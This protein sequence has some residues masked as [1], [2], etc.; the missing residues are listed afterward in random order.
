[1]GLFLEGIYF[2]NCLLDGIYLG[3][4]LLDGIYLGIYLLDG[5]I[6]ML[7]QTYNY[8]ISEGKGIQASLESLRVPACTKDHLN[9]L[10]NSSHRNRLKQM[11]NQ[12][13]TQNRQAKQC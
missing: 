1:V 7:M 5:N 9:C 13:P 11:T 2:G 6:G 12:D 8:Q 10:L 4:C 3:I